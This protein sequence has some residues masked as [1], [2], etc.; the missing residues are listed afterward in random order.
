M[1]NFA[2]LRLPLFLAVGFLFFA[3][4]PPETVH[5]EVDCLTCHEALSK[6]KVVHPALQ[7]GCP[8]CHTGIDAAEVP[9]KKTNKIARGLS[10]AQPELCYG[11]HDKKTFTKKTVHAA[12]A[13]GCTGC[14]NPHSSKN[15]KLLVAEPPALCFN[16]H[17]KTKF[18]G[19]TVHSPVAGGMCT[20]CHSP[21][22]TDTPKLLVSETPGLCFNC[23]DKAEFTR[24]NVHA[25]VQG[26]MCLQCH[27]SIHASKEPA[28][29]GKRINAVCVVCHQEVPRSPHAVRGLK[30][31]GHPLQGKKDPARNDKPFSCAS[32]HNPHS[33]DSPRLF[34]YAASSSYEL[35]GHCHNY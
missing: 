31:E 24:K 2:G 1:K 23:H 27:T 22:S 18:E 35:C 20:A 30:R 13:M 21:H 26:G 3:S 15:A 33:S 19:K 4:M 14:H 29:L 9:H 5:A 25:P 34:R 12:V 7:M 10:S 11:C 8:T 32:C 16:C 28:L 6:E 17:D